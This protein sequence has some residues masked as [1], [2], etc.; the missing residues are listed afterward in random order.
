MFCLYSELAKCPVTALIIKS[1]KTIIQ[2]EEGMYVA[3]I[4]ALRNACTSLIR[5]PKKYLLVNLV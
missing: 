5:K 4:G 3:Y 2:L 1:R